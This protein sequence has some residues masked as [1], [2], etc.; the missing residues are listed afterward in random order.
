MCDIDDVGV[1]GMASHANFFLYV[2]YLAIVE[3]VKARF[4]VF[5]DACVC[6]EAFTDYQ[7]YAC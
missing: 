4:K 1:G 2:L 5:D 3:V 7:Q 6:I